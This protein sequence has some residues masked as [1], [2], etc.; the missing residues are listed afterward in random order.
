[1]SYIYATR[2]PRTDLSHGDNILVTATAKCEDCGRTVDLTAT[3]PPRWGRKRPSGGHGR[4]TDYPHVALA[5]KRLGNLASRNG[6]YPRFI[7][8]DDGV[9]VDHFLITGMCE[10]CLGEI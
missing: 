2:D 5:R 9:L 8:G 10:D 4:G 7:R 1:M 3:A 6:I